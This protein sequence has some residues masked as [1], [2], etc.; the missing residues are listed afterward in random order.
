MM[1]PLAEGPG[2]REGQWGSGHHLEAIPPQ[3]RGTPGLGAQVHRRLVRPA[4]GQES[5]ESGRR[6]SRFSGSPAP[7]P[8]AQGVTTVGRE[9]PRAT[10]E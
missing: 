4:Q 9:R 6:G 3:L 1:K 5:S 8:E 2:D 10:K 7:S